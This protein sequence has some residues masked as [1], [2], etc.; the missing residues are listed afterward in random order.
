MNDA[1][2]RHRLLAILA[3]DA[4][5]YSRLMAADEQATVAALD[6]ARGVFAQ[7]V[8]AHAG[9]IVDTAGDSVLAV[10]ETA[11]GA[12]DAALAIQARLALDGVGTPPD[13]QMPF[14]IGVHLGDV[15]EKPDGSVYGNGVNVA[16][17]LQALAEPGGIWV[18]DTV[19]GTIGVRPGRRF[20]DR[21][22]QT[23]KNIAEP[24]HAFRLHGVEPLSP[25]S[26]GQPR[27]RHLIVLGATIVGIALAA[28]LWILPLRPT[29]SPTSPG[30]AQGL[31]PLSLMIGT[32]AATPGDAPA[33]EVAERL[34]SDLSAGL[35]GPAY[36]NSYTVLAAR[37]AAASGASASP[38]E[39]ARHVGA[40][41]LLEGGVR[42]G[43]D[44]YAATLQIVETPSG[45]QKW[46]STV[47][48]KAVDSAGVRS[49]AVQELVGQI[50][51]YVF[52]SE[53][54]RVLALPADQLV[55]CCVLFRT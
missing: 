28:A 47:E 27:R 2:S 14:R 13:R 3:A 39:Q 19:R 5:G 44:G 24:V 29:G 45:A 25:G 20:D 6:A 48:L 4:T 26:L 18:S 50:A 41:F 9:R 34:R 21:G 54:Q 30:A 35:S 12:V 33:A 52:A 37:N 16:A 43:G 17:R 36:R 31:L 55:Q 51:S 23:V 32:I 7:Q 22:R 49:R 42:R 46:S 8:R 53:A 15:I 11:A 38:L 1:G 40:R 10:F